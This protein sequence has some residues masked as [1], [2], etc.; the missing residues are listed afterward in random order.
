MTTA[1]SITI[2]HTPVNGCVSATAAKPG[3]DDREP[4]DG[5]RV[6]VAQQGPADDQREPGGEHRGIR[7]P[8]PDRVQVEQ[9]A[10]P[11]RIEAPTDQGGEERPER[12]PAPA[13]QR[14]H[15]QLEPHEEQDEVGNG[16]HLEH[17]DRRQAGTPS[18]RGQDERVRR[19][20]RRREVRLGELLRRVEQVVAEGLDRRLVHPIVR[21][22]L[23]VHGLGAQQHDE[24]EPEDEVRDAGAGG[25]A[26]R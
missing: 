17:G 9:A 1:P 4:G 21:R 25:H 18:D 5:A 23:A 6:V 24:H 26:A 20:A 11:P 19:V 8:E 15:E 10:P 13:G 14:R 7:Q 2:D 12:D 3:A 22:P 16:C